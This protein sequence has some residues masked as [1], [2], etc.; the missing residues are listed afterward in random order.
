MKE[1]ALALWLL[2][3]SINLSASEQH[4]KIDSLKTVLNS[5]SSTIEKVNLLNAIALKYVHVKYDSIKTNAERP[6]NLPK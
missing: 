2:F 4:P 6:Y 1:Y 3:F 5:T